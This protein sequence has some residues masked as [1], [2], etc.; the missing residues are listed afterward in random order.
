MHD[1]R[2]KNHSQSNLS[3]PLQGTLPRDGGFYKHHTILD[4]VTSLRVV[5]HSE[6]YLKG[7]IDRLSDIMRQQTRPLRVGIFEGAFDPPHRGHEETAR[8]AIGI[9]NLDLL[10]VSCYH[11]AHQW[12]P[13]LSP[14]DAR[15]EMTASYFKRAPWTVV[16]PLARNALEQLL[17]S[18]ITTGVIGSDTFNRFLALGI[19]KGFNTDSILVTERRDYPLKSAP[20]TLNGHPVLYVGATQL[21]FNTSSSTEIRASLGN[22]PG[23]SIHPMLNEQTARIAR[24]RDLDRL[25]SSTLQ[26]GGSPRPIPERPEGPYQSHSITRRRGLMNGLLSESFI[27]EAQTR[28]GET[29]AFRKTRPPHRDPLK[30]LS[31]ELFGLKEFNRLN[32][33]NAYA[34]PARLVEEPLS[35]WVERA[36]GETLTSLLIGYERGQRSAKDALAGLQGVGAMLRALHSKRLLPSS[37]SASTIVR[38]HLDEV[39]ALTAACPTWQIN[40]PACQKALQEFHD[41]GESLLRT[42]ARC[43]LVHGD[44]NC[45]NFLWDARHRTVWVIDLERFGAQLRTNY[46]GLPSYEYHQL[47]SSLHYFPNFGFRGV[48]GRSEYLLRGLQEAYGELPPAE[49]TFFSARWTLQRLLGRHLRVVPPQGR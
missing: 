28:S 47:I 23:A 39:K 46:L 31:D 34:P 43:S 7:L 45:G 17:Q 40:E 16:S 30:S 4:L 38:M 42:G 37:L 29:V 22:R 26:P 32:L 6:K 49:N 18:H 13:H 11:S 8:A 48:Q 27:D 15:L 5:N 41:A 35:L 9:A 25:A 20:I 14:H 1:P 21:A 36:P 33:P 24:T 44:A 10:I 12:K 2:A 19:P 3:N